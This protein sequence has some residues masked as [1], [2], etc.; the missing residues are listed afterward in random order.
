ML[1]QRQLPEEDP[2]AI[3]QTNMNTTEY[4]LVS[5]IPDGRRYQDDGVHSKQGSQLV[6]D[7]REEVTK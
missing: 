3:C 2:S 7:L 4:Q 6:S 5:H 1:Q